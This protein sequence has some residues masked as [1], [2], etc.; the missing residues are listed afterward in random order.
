MKRKYL[1]FI[2]LLMIFL[3]LYALDS[4]EDEE[5][6]YL[7][8]NAQNDMIA[9]VQYTSPYRFSDDLNQGDKIIYQ[10]KNQTNNVVS[11]EVMRKSQTEIEIEEKFEGNIV[12]Y[13]IDPK[14]KKIIKLSGS[15]EEGQQ[16]ECVLLPIEEVNRRIQSMREPVSIRFNLQNTQKS[17][18]NIASKNLECTILMP[19]MKDDNESDEEQN[20]SI[21][22]NSPIFSKDIPY[23]LPVKISNYIFNNEQVFSNFKEGFVKNNSYEIKEFNKGE[24]K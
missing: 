15:D 10:T 8:M 7:D 5:E 2:G 16:Y 24:I 23:M 9:F 20:N 11:L 1:M 18:M 6:S 3:S 22:N 13:I 21:L 12:H 14:T 4:Y 17:S 19:T